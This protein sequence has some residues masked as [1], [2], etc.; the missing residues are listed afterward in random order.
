MHHALN[1]HQLAKILV[2]RRQNPRL[3]YGATE[4]FF[5]TRVAWPIAR[6][7]HVVTCSPD[8]VG[9]Q[10]GNTAVQQR[11]HAADPTGNGSTRSC[12]TSL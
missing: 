5:I 11:P 4:D 3:G 10:R 12:A 9:R 2:N 1:D 8:Y 6:T 7:Y